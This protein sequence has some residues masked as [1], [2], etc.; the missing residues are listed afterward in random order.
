MFPTPCIQARTG[1]PRKCGWSRARHVLNEY[2]RVD[3]VIS[4]DAPRVCAPRFALSLARNRRLHFLGLGRFQLFSSRSKRRGLRS[5]SPQVIGTR[6]PT[7]A[8]SV[9]VVKPRGQYDE[10]VVHPLVLLSVVDHFRRVEEV[11]APPRRA[12]LN[13]VPSPVRWL[14]LPP[15]FPTLSPGRLRGQ[16][17]GWR[18]AWRVPQG[19]AR[20]DQLVRG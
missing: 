15:P 5:R 2:D 19:A 13:R 20:C 10:V 8:A 1:L 18:A 11:R 4:F 16:T 6:P 9:E 17:R 12:D 7:M 14:N 3:Y